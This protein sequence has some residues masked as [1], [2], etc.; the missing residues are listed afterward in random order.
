VLPRD[1][2]LPLTDF[3]LE[4][5]EPLRLAHAAADGPFI[6]K[7]KWSLHPATVSKSIGAV[8]E[9]LAEEDKRAGRT[10]IAEFNHRDL[11]RTCE[12]QSA[13]APRAHRQPRLLIRLRPHCVRFAQG[14]RSRSFTA[15]SA[16]QSDCRYSLQ[17]ERALAQLL[18]PDR[19]FNGP[20]VLERPCP[21][22]SAPGVYASLGCLLQ[23][24]QASR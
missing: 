7:A 22:P 11:R 1:H 4:I 21:L 18:H 10:P 9:A 24:L 16:L 17:M 5:L 8:W 3:A 12:T 19:L 23:Q 14:R 15:G 2:L 13:L 20:D 6:S